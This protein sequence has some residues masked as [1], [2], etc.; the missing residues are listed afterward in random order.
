MIGRLAA[1]TLAAALLGCVSY[2][3][4]RLG[5]LTL[6]SNR[7]VPIRLTVVQRDV[8]G[9]HCEPIT[10]N[11]SPSLEAA[12]DIAQAQAPEADALADV[13][14]LMIRRGSP[15]VSL[16]FSVTADAVKFR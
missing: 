14:V 3:L 12:I 15:N 10:S 13:V 7:N 2:D 8:H 11:R 5:D 16:C 9:E 6:V 4:T 1:I